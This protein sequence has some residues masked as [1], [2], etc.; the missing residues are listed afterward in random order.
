MPIISKVGR[1]RQNIVAFEVLE[2]KGFSEDKAGNAMPMTMTASGAASHG[3][4]S[5]R[6]GTAGCVDQRGAKVGSTL[7]ETMELD[8]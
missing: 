6:R 2:S 3:R 7:P 4:D 1:Q 8:G 5:A